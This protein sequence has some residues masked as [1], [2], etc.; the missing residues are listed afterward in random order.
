[1][2]SFIRLSTFIGCL[3]LSMQVSASALADERIETIK[4]I[5][6]SVVAIATW[7][8][9]RVPALKFVGTGFIV[10]DGL[11]VITNAHVVSNTGTGDE[12]ETLGIVAGTAQNSQFRE[13]R[14]VNA[15][16]EYDLAQLRISGT[17]IPALTLA[18]ADHVEEGKTLL[19]TGFPLGMV[20]GFHHV[21]HQAMVSAV[22]PIAIPAAR[23]N[24]LNADTI[25][26]LQQS[27]YHVYQLDGT[28]YPGNSGSPLYDPA[29]GE[30]VGV[31][32]KVFIKGTKET[33]ITQPSGITY[34]IPGK[35]ILELLDQ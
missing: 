17:P 6:P 3:L 27:P 11:T 31:I 5:K 33:A 19:F 25:R 35:Y 16:A 20:L 28:A 13:A 18:G 4:R 34:A 14:L 32:N 12:P 23:A 15:A 22:T 2:T 8:K 1:M 29:T 7:N 21:T 26:R 30:V 10:R 24:R 9:T